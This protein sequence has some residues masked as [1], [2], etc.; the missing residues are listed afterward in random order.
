MT[1]WEALIE[2]L[3][4]TE[5]QDRIGSAWRLYFHLISKGSEKNR[6]VTNYHELEKALAAPVATIKKWKER[7]LEQG[8][9]KCET[10]KYSFTLILL[11]PYDITLTCVKTDMTEIQL[12]SDPETKKLITKLFST[13]NLSVLPMIADLAYKLELLEKRL[14]PST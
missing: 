2:I 10:G 1:R 12:K 6:F 9:A 7:L 4:S 11:P 13:N 14:N 8:V 3:N 5:R